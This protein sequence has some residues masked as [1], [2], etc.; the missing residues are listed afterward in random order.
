MLKLIRP[1]TMMAI[2][3][4]F[5]LVYPL[6]GYSSPVA[7]TVEKID[8]AQFP[9]PFKDFNSI[10]EIQ[11]STITLH[12]IS[13][14]GIGPPDA[15]NY[16]LFGWGFHN[17]SGLTFYDFHLKFIW[18]E[19]PLSAAYGLASTVYPNVNP[20]LIETG[21]QPPGTWVAL[22][23]WADQPNGG[24]KDGEFFQVVFS[25]YDG[26]YPW[27][28]VLLP[29]TGPV[30]EPATMLLLGSGLLGLLGVGKKFRK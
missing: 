28:L 24:I 4:A 11:A 10:S 19:F 15:A 25:R 6:L 5:F 26:E 2:F 9:F 7:F 8:E 27:T 1:I 18:E 13:D 20:E 30:P 29:S 3:I 22:T 12:K 23:W 14:Q 16:G 21:D 17:T